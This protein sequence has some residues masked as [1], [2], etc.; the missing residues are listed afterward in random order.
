MPLI[1]PFSQARTNPTF[2]W[3]VSA[4]HLNKRNF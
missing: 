1:V 4:L 3:S 2:K